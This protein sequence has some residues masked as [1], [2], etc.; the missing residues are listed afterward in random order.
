MDP[1]AHRSRGRS[2]GAD[3]YWQ[4]RFFTLV[5]GLGVVG[6]L[7]WAC[8]GVASGGN[9]SPSSGSGR[10]SS[11]AYGTTSG[12]Q[13]PSQTVTSAPANPSPSAS[14]TVA[15]A[16]SP[17]GSVSPS[18][19][20]SGQGR[21]AQAAHPASG[22]TACPSAD[23]VL[24]L[25]ATKAS[26]GPQDTPAFQVDIVSTGTATC[27]LDT[28][29]A[30]LRLLVLHGTAVAYNSAICLNGAQRHVISLRRGVPV[31]T[32]MAWNKHE[33]VAGCRSTV[34][35]AANRTYSALAQ[36]GGAE[37]PRSSF[38]LTGA[39]ATAKPAAPAA[40]TTARSR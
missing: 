4:R 32:S 5:A 2:S 23:L 1:N 26:Y 29:P 39:P 33:T 16:A 9:S 31:V 24:T 14:P 21:P 3:A 22:P 11:A 18:A 37:S 34:L 13:S 36:A 28:G 7:A 20:A 38:R 35:A 10:P 17:S 6:L 15:P 12:T 27:T 30:A 19:S 25:T 40:R 8:S